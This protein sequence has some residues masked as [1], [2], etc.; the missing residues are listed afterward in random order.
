MNQLNFEVFPSDEKDFR[1]KIEPDIHDKNLINIF[2]SFTFITPN[3]SVLFTL[4]ELKKFTE[5]ITNH[6]VFLVLWDMNTL[7]NPYF[8]RMSASGKTPDWD[9]FI[10]EKIKEVR[11]IVTMVGFKKDEIN[12]YKSSDLWKRF[13][14]YKEENIFQRFYSALAQ[15]KI[16]DYVANNKVSHLFQV[17]MDMFFCNYFHK[18]YPE[19]ISKSIDI[20]FYGQDKEKLYLT[21]RQFMIDD[22]IISD[23]KPIFVRV[24]SF[25]YLIYNANV[26][27]WNMSL[28]D[29]R[30]II[31]NFPLTKEE[32]IVLFRYIF[33]SNILEEDFESFKK[34]NGKKGC[35]ELK[36][37]LAKALYKYLQV[38]KK[39]FMEI[40]GQI[41][42]DTI[43]VSG[44]KE[45]RDFG[46]ILKS[47][48]ALEII[49]MADGTKNTTEMS[50]KIGKS[51]AT[52]STYANR[53]KRKKLIEVL[54]NGNI[55]RTVN[56]LKINF[57]IGIQKD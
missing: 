23:K 12:I 39:R 55:K 52:I 24:K 21:T 53:L 2:C 46:Q 54:P 22:C 36:E 35:N 8:R 30:N 47:N 48:I 32:V 14:S 17:P 9:K 45:A 40:S 33:S 56:V 13:V 6:K 34:V 18:L 57:D 3:Y 10:N 28:R 49:L 50:K 19:D 44:R 5:T 25:P 7:S 1:L 31:L 15:M 37:I 27:E 41:K 26:P 16:Q 51:I 38:S 42:E 43:N 4:S 29:I 11:E 20:A